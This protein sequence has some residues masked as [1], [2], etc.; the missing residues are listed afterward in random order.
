MLED[1][2]SLLRAEGAIAIPGIEV[3]G[4]YGVLGEYDFVSIVRHRTT[5]PPPS[6]RW[7]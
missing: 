4:L 5:N 3:L 6:S 7:R 1:S 2:E